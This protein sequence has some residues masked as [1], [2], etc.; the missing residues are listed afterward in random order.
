MV[1]RGEIGLLIV[2]I[3]L[4]ETPFLSEEAFVTATWATVLST[5]I[6]P[7]VVGLLLKRHKYAISDDLQWGMQDTAH[8]PGWFSDEA[9]LEEG[10]ASRWASRRHSRAISRAASERSRSRAQSRAPSMDQRANASG[11]RTPLSPR[12][13]GG[14]GPDPE[15]IRRGLRNA[16][17]SDG[18][19]QPGDVDEKGVSGSDKSDA[20]D[21]NP[22]VV[23]ADNNEPTRR[24]VINF[25]DTP[26]AE[27]KMSVDVRGEVKDD[28]PSEKP[29]GP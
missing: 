24:R 1:A 21:A 26:A 27:R 16:G 19:L 23:I 20:G 6:G 13:A 3:G 9:I 7:V 5:I 8:N 22:T 28:T 12:L 4:N 18:N 15:E 25:D 2:Q 10:R 17:G 11:D 14:G 29:D